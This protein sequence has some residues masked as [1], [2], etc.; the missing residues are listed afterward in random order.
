MVNKTLTKSPFVYH[1][2]D[3]QEYPAVVEVYQ[4]KHFNR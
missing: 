1:E 3:I 4:I 2:F